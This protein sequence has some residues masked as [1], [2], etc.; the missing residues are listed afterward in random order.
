MRPIYSLSRNRIQRNHSIDS[1]I[2]TNIGNASVS[3]VIAARNS[4]ENTRSLGLIAPSHWSHTVPHHMPWAT[5]SLAFCNESS[6]NAA[7]MR[8][9]AETN[10]VTTAI[11]QQLS[12]SLPTYFS[13][14]FSPDPCTSQTATEW[15]LHHGNGGRSLKCNKH[16]KRRSSSD[17][18]DDDETLRQPPTKQ[19]ISEAKV[20]AR[21]GAMSLDNHHDLPIIEEPEEENE[22]AMNDSNRSPNLVVC[23]EIQ[24]TFGA[25]T[26]VD[27]VFREEIEKSSKAVVL[28]QPSIFPLL[29]ASEE[30]EI[31]SCYSV[32][33]NDD[34]SVDKALRKTDEM[35]ALENLD[36]D[37]I[38]N[39]MDESD[40][41]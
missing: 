36:E 40:M 12:A 31:E 2:G 27:K 29:T 6:T 9:T 32:E 35:E 16:L 21:F 8:F 7:V 15:E 3:E 22:E 18:D 23:E 41:M 5:T 24:Q 26:A 30:K 25:K 19:Y 1:G 11:Q 20:A 13:P 14:Y 10:P 33:L 28:W 39:D 34:D 4:D 38:S 37:E 17:D